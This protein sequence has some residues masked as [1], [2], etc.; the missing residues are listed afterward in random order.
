MCIRDSFRCKLCHSR[1]YKRT[2]CKHYND[3]HQLTT[4]NAL[5]EEELQSHEYMKT[6]AKGERVDDTALY[7]DTKR[8]RLQNK[9]EEDRLLMQTSVSREL[10]PDLEPCVFRGQRR[11]A[12]SEHT[13]ATIRCSSCKQ[14]PMCSG[15]YADPRKIKALIDTFGDRERLI[16]CKI[17]KVYLHVRCA[18]DQGRCRRCAAIGISL[19]RRSDPEDREHAKWD[20]FLHKYS[21]EDCWDTEG[22]APPESSGSA[23][24][25]VSYTHLTLPTICSV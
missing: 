24:G 9:V 17:C 1:H 21:E 7:D 18:N 23:S 13:D 4:I 15:C 14:N 11:L 10:N 20:Q 8:R 25:A 16:C 12:V 5:I 22:G 19:K 3:S 6:N 2:L